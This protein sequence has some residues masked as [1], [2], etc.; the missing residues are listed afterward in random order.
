[1]GVGEEQRKKRKNQ[2]KIPC[3]W[4]KQNEMVIL[5]KGADWGWKDY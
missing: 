4:L 5:K 3:F 1:M 2:P